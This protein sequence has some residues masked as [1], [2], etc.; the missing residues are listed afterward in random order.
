MGLKQMAALPAGSM[1]IFKHVT[2]DK[3]FFFPLA[4][5]DTKDFSHSL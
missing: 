4:I 5:S 2:N 3:V 1:L